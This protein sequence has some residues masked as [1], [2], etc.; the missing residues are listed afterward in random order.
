MFPKYQGS[1]QMTA[2]STLN[3][4]GSGSNF[5]PLVKRVLGNELYRVNGAIEQ[6]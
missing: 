3:D 6:K 2:R 5:T 1:R 4:G